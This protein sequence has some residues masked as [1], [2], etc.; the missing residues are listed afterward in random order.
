MA[1]DVNDEPWMTEVVRRAFTLS[2]GPFVDV[3]VNLGQTLLKVLSIDP[4][5]RYFGFEPNPTCVDYVDRLIQCN[6]LE[7]ATLFPFGLASETGVE[8]LYLNPKG[9]HDSGA[10]IIEGFRSGVTYRKL[11]PV[12]SWRDIPSNLAP[13]SAALVK[14]DVEGAELS[15]LQGMRE[16]LFATQPPIVIEILPVY[17][18]DNT[19]RLNR[20]TE[21]VK[22]MRGIGYGFHRIRPAKS[23]R[24]VGFDSV[25]EPGIHGNL[26]L[27]NYLLL[28]TD[29]PRKA[30]LLHMP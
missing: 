10:S 12:F 14:I 16:F 11:V 30:E 26:D 24:L 4:T 19:A 6:R 27:C 9:A 13:K 20:Q 22:L 7:N 23:G 15:V 5:R 17:S 8:S 29:Q 18:A 3:G 21:L 25:D 28:H 2:E 1:A